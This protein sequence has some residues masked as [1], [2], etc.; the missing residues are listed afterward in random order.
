MPFAC[1]NNA[2]VKLHWQYCECIITNGS[3]NALPMT[4]YLRI[5]N[6]CFTTIAPG[7]LSAA[8]PVLLLRATALI[9]FHHC[10][11]FTFNL[12]LVAADCL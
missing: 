2:F 7:I 5:V 11:P 8:A 4:H 12:A 3:F 9:A 6:A 10:F 1:I